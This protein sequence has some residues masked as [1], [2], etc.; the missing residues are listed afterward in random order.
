MRS[1]GR[2]VGPPS[3]SGLAT[4]A[5]LL[6]CALVAYRIIDPPGFD[7]AAVVKWGAPAGLVCAGLVA[8]GSR[9]ALRAEREHPLSAE[10]AEP[11]PAEAAD[12]EAAG[13][14]GDGDPAD[15]PPSPAGAA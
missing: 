9:M 5:G 15:A 14:A 6:A 8:I 11:A 3:L 2:E 1:I 13:P 4:L 7:E 12:A 10:A